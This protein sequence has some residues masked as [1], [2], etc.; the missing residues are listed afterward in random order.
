MDTGTLV[1]EVTVEGEPNF[2]FSKVTVTVE[3]TQDD[4]TALSRT[5]TNRQNNVWTEENMPPGQYL[6]QAASNPRGSAQARIR[7]GQTTPVSVPL[8]IGAITATQ[9]LVHFRFDKAFVEPC[10]RPVL[11]QVADH[12]RNHTNEKLVIVG[13]TDKVDVPK[14]NQSLSERRA[15]A[16]FA[17]LTFGRDRTGALAEWNAL[18]L[19]KSVRFPTVN[20]SWGTREYQ[21]MLQDLG[22]YPG[23]VDGKHGDLTDDAVRAFR[24]HKGLPPG[25]TVDD[26]VW[27]A[28]IEDYLGQDNLAVPPERFFANCATEILKWL[29]CG[30]EDPVKNTGAA[31]R[32]SR[33][34]ELLFVQTDRLSCQVPPPD[35]FNLPGTPAVNSNWCV[36]PGA[37]DA[38]C[39]FVSRVVK[40]DTAD[41]PQP[42]S[43][44]PNGPWCREFA[45]TGTITV[46]GSIQRERP[47]G[48]LELVG[49]QAYVLITPKGEF[50]RSEA[51]SGEPVPDR[52]KKSS[53]TDPGTFKYEN[54]AP[55][56]YTLE[57]IAPANKP[58]L[59][60]LL[61]EPDREIKGNIVC[62]ALRVPQGGGNAP[63]LDVVI[64]NAPVFRE[65]RLRVV[66]HLMTPLVGATHQ[67]R[68]CPDATGAPTPQHTQHSDADIRQFFD[69]ANTI[70]RQARIRFELA[71]I[72]REAYTH[73]IDDPVGRGSCEVDSNEFQFL[74]SRCAYPNAVNV[75][76]FADLAG[77]GEAGLGVSKEN[78][79]ALGVAGCAVGDRFQ[80]TILGILQDRPL[81]AEQTIQVLAHELGH[82]LNLE[83]VDDTAANADRLMLPSTGL[84]GANRRLAPDEVSRARASR[85]ATDDCVPLE[86]R[87]SGATQIGGSLSHEFIVIQNPAGVVTVDAEIPDRLLAPEVGT[88]TMTGGNPGANAKQRTVSAA[89]AGPPVDVVASYTPA[90]GNVVTA[91]AVIRVATFT[92][93]VE[94]AD[95]I[96]PGS[97]DFVARRDPVRAVTIVA[98][99]N[100]TPFCVPTNLV[101][102]TGGDEAADPL[103]R[104]FSRNTIARTTVS[105][106]VAGRQLSVTITVIEVALTTNVPPFDARITEV[107]IEG[108]LNRDLV[109]GGG[110]FALADL[111]GTQTSSL[112]RARADLPGVSGTTFTATILSNPPSGVTLDEP[113]RNITLTRT[114]GDRF[115]SRPMLMI[116]AAI[117]RAEINAQGLEVIRAKAGGTVRVTL[118][119]LFVGHG[120]QA[121]VRGRIMHVFAQAFQ[122]SGVTAAD[123]R[124]HI[125]RANRAWAQ[126]GIEVKER[127]VNASVP[128]P[129]GLLE[130]D[131]NVP[132]NGI[133]TAEERQLLGI[134]RPGNPARSTVA[135]DVNI[136]YLEALARALATAYESEHHPE[137]TDP[138]Q[139]GIA[140]TLSDALSAV[141]NDTTL[142]HEMGHLILVRWG[143]GEHQELSGSDWPAG[144]VMHTP[145][146]AIDLDRTQVENILLSVGSGTN[147]FIIF[148]P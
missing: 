146:S 1:V 60:R 142:S 112:F 16:V 20:D 101:T 80:F 90:S 77:T 50:K 32:P 106:T 72:V 53:E 49:N 145:A 107:L 100:P 135:T 125:R 12:A 70:W 25:T 74:L 81:D 133:L 51:A 97:T 119:G 55:G 114:S 111:I 83:H 42:C 31:H 115:V 38:H 3:G 37:A 6:V 113:P 105:A 86:L 118:S 15:R 136:Y 141:E 48:T 94:G 124:R 40:P 75:F 4:G 65:I 102:W 43:T 46:E 2:D 109:P 57:V 96:A 52:T 88:L 137:I 131:Q 19:Q 130:L 8:R 30:E 128:A 121:T 78:G 17:F 79:A 26:D 122:G 103:R 18:R 99:I 132:F 13:H 69:G 45:E 144:N 27:N 127:Q 9:F 93:R 140:I 24:C 68:T 147:P 23:A 85:G 5:L 39:C 82:F 29:G 64:V 61:E 67:I 7:A 91:L 134:V 76:F 14:Y 21:H 71:D 95:P 33:R 73:P 35:T 104:T 143:A 92:L 138:N 116:P 108:V 117:S 59:V 98:V 62:K 139:S 44:D 84:T 110:T 41:T 36:G 10:M 129:A 66:A 56:V 22:F 11:R 47:D 123:V 87:V 63:K 148:E 120:A 126:A 54:M 58:V 89:T 34:V 28:L